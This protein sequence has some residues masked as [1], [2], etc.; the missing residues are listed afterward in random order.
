MYQHRDDP[1]VKP[2]LLHYKN[3]GAG[4]GWHAQ[5]TVINWGEQKVIHYPHK[6]DFT[7]HGGKTGIN[8]SRQR[9]LLPFIRK[10]KRKLFWD[11]SLSDTTLEKG[12]KD[13]L[14]ARFVRQLT[15]L[16]DP[17]VLVEAGSYFGKTARV[18]V[19]SSKETRAA[20]FGCI[21]YNFNLDGNYF[22]YNDS[23]ARGVRLEGAVGAGSEKNE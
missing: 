14:M 21:S 19:S 15:G 1:E 20:W 9:T 12:L 17:S 3:H 16:Q 4:Y 10:E 11:R 2:I 7:E 5:N 6:N 8:Q 23:A 22:L 18:W 13:S